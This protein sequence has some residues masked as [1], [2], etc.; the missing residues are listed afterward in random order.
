M[1]LAALGG[2]FSLVH[3]LVTRGAKLLS[4]DTEGQHP[5]AQT[6]SNGHHVI[7]DYLFYELRKYP[8]KRT[9]PGLSLYWMLKYAAKR[10]DDYRIRYLLSQGT[11]VNFQ[12]PVQSQP[13]LS[14]ALQSAPCLLS[15]AKLLLENGADPNITASL[16]A[17]TPRGRPPRQ[18]SA[19]D[20]ALKREE[21]LRLVELLLQYGVEPSKSC[22][23]LIT[24][25]QHEKPAEF[26]L[27][28][29]KVRG[30]LHAIAGCLWRRRP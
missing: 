16:P 3:I 14:S 28:V 24:A 26:R 18:I 17:G 12:L 15:T 10:G 8:Y 13:A 29:E 4:H 6:A 1:A 27:L 21:S 25:V 5:L 19:I 22:Q 23:A 7:E 20:Q 30:Y 11:N 2:H 9:N